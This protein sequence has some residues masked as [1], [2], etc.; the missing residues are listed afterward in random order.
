MATTAG[1][2]KQVTEKEKEDVSKAMKQ[3]MN[4]LPR[5]KL[6][7]ISLKESPVLALQAA[8]N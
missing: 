4:E 6:R 2:G 1:H 5:S 8:G 3:K 7:G